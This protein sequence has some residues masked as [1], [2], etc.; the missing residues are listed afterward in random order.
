MR[1]Q[2]GRKMKFHTGASMYITCQSKRLNKNPVHIRSSRCHSVTC[3]TQ[4]LW[5]DRRA[6]CVGVDRCEVPTVF[7]TLSLNV[8][9][10]KWQN[11]RF[12]SVSNVVI[13]FR[14][15]KQCYISFSLATNKRYR[16]PIILKPQFRIS[17]GWIIATL[18]CRA[19]REKSRAE[20]PKIPRKSRQENHW[21]YYWKIII[22][23]IKLAISSNR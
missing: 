21:P 5:V 16:H 9:W 2:V 7:N 12:K 1:F 22:I 6:C 13:G 15:W 10:W 11:F 3:V 17:G 14:R 18:T 20:R 8:K 19:Y 4:Y 23:I